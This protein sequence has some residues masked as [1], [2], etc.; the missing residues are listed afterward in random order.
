MRT[1]LRSVSAAG[2]L[3]FL[4]V[5]IATFATPRFFERQAR[6][7]LVERLRAETVER[8]P[9]LS[10]VEAGLLA[11]LCKHD[12]AEPAGL[13]ALVRAA[14][15][16]VAAQDRVH[17]LE[18]GLDRV[19][20]WAQ[21]RFDALV[22]RFLRDVRIFALT[23]ALMFLLAFLVLAADPP[24][25]VALIVSGALI[26]G[27]AAGTALYLFAQDWLQTFIFSDYLGATYAIWVALIVAA[28]LDVLLNR[29]RL[30]GSLVGGWAVHPP[31]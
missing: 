15:A 28:E 5:A 17:R 18:E 25:R 27:A 7:Y 11:A 3:L 14:L 29:A 16:R 26:A 24:P 19:K 6:H 12:C 30:L 22:D 31:H 1:A 13:P 4:A 21:G 20:R 9:G 23:N 10:G 8:Y 2:L